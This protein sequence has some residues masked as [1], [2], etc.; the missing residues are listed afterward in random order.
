[1]AIQNQVNTGVAIAVH[2]EHQ[3]TNVTNRAIVVLPT[4]NEAENL[5]LIVPLILQEDPRLEILVVDDN[6]PDGT[7]KIADQLA[8]GEERIH[9]MHRSHKEGLGRAYLAGFQRAL[10]LGADLII[11]MDA[12]FSHPV[13]TL[14]L[15]LKEIEEYDV[16]VGS[17]YINGI[18]VVNWS[19]ER[20]L[21]SYFGNWY[22]RKVTGLKIADATGGLRCIRRSMLERIDLDRIQS[23]GY[24]FQIELN[25]RLY[26]RGARVKEVPFLFVDRTRGNSKLTLMVGVECLWRSPWLRLTHWLN[27][28]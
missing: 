4:Y 24:S 23:N 11:Q 16:V 10:E 21:L 19:I 5:P 2:G 7:G 13:A 26:K 3:E 8:A 25:Y 22:V 6:S 27:R 12:D 14:S 15:M 28:L 20:I 1:M 18:S 17:R 9:V